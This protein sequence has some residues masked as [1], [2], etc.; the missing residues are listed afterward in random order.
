V[1]TCQQVLIVK[2]E[3]RTQVLVPQT[4][5]ENT[6]V[7]MCRYARIQNIFTEKTIELSAV[8]VSTSFVVCQTYKCEQWLYAVNS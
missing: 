6:L 4:H 5:L 7:D 3:A 2:L 8:H 1:V